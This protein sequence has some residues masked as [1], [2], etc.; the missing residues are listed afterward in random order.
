MGFQ[1]FSR[2]ILAM[3]D[4]KLSTSPAY[5]TDAGIREAVQAINLSGAS[6]VGTTA[7][8]N[9]GVTF[10][11]STGTGAGW[12]LPLAPPGK[13]GVEKTVFIKLN[14]AS[15]VPVSVRTASSSQAFW[16][17]TRNSFSV[18]TAAG[19]TYGVCVTLMSRSSVQWALK[20]AAG[21]LPSTAFPWVLTT[22]ATA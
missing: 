10:I 6:G 7:V 13:G 18:S 8:T 22:A 20:A 12:T 11:L 17:S 21:G 9:R 1:K 16:N 3:R 19:S 15:T 4:V 2:P 5:S 14:G